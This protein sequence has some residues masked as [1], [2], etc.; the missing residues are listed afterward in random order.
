M[1]AVEAEVHALPLPAPLPLPLPLTQ[2]QH[3]I[4]LGQ[5][6]D[7]GN[8][9]YLTAE[10][11]ELTGPLD[12]DA[13][14]RAV[15]EVLDA[16]DALHMRCR[17]QGDAVW[18]QPQR[19][20]WRMARAD[21]RSEPDA[22]QA[23]HEWM[24]AA[25]QRPLDLAHDRLFDTALLRLDGQRHLWFFSAHHIALDGFGHALIA[26]ALAA[27][28]VHL[29]QHGGTPATPMDGSLARV[30]DEDQAY[31]ASAHCARDR[32]FWQQ[33]LE[34]A[35]AP[36]S[37]APPAAL[38]QTVRRGPG[39]IHADRHAAWQ[40]AARDAGV[41]VSAWLLAAVAAWLHG[42]T[43]A[44]D[45]TLGLPVM[46]RLGSATLRRPCMAMN[47]VPLRL[48]IEPHATPA[49]LA[50]QVAD[51]LRTQRP[52]QRYR[53]EHL[54]HDLGQSHGQNNARNTTPTRLFGPVV[55]WM[56]FDRPLDFGPGLQASSLPVA[57][58]PVEDLSITI[59]P[60][61]AAWQFD[62]DAN[63][64]AYRAD[65]LA[66]LRD[67][68]LTTLDRLAASPGEPLAS[69][70]PFIISGGPL[71]NAA[72]AVLAAF[73]A[74]ARATPAKTALEHEGRT[75]TYAELLHAVQSLAGH[76]K[77]RGVRADTR[78][79]VLL[80]RSPQAITALLAV[81]W[82]GGCYVP[83][84][85]DS[86]PARIAM[87]LNDAQPAW[88]LTLSEHLG[89]WH[90]DTPS[91]C[92][93]HDAPYEPPLAD[94]AEVGAQA[95]AYVIYTSGSTGQPNG[96]MIGRHALAH[97]IAGAHARY[98]ITR[99]DRMLQF[100]PLHFDASVEEI[101]LPLTAGATL[102]LR[103]DA[104]LESLPHFVAACA[105]QRIS[106]LDLPTAFWH[107]LA[108][109]L[110]HTEA[111][112]PPSVRLVVIGGEAALAER[113]ARWRASVP[114]HVRLLNTYGPTEATVVCTTAPLAGPGA[115][116]W[117]GDTVPIGQPLPGM[118]LVV[119]NAAL[120]PLPQGAAGELCLIGEAL[121][122]GYLGREERSAQR[123][124][125]L[126]ALPG[127]PRAYRTGDHVQVGP[128]GELRYLG[129]LDDELK[130][131]GHRIDP[132][133][134]ETTL[135]AAPGVRE[136]AVVGQAL[137]D[138]NKRLVAFIVADESFD[139]R[140]F[141]ANALRAFAAARLPAVAVPSAHVQLARLPRNLN[142]KID[143]NALREQAAS[144]HLDAAVDVAT[145]ASTDA[146]TSAPTHALEQAV[147][148]VWREVLG[149]QGVGATADF[150]A[151]GGKSLQAIQVANRLGVALQ[152]EVA[153]S[154]LFLHP[155]VGALAQA[156]AASASRGVGH[157]PP[158]SAAGHELAPL[159]AIQP[160]AEGRDDP[161]LFCIH[162][163]E[164]LAWCYFGLSRALPGV[165]LWGLQ[166]QG[167]TGEAPASFDAM[168]Q[169]GVR[170]IR[171]QQPHGPYHLLGWSSGGGLAHALA[172]RLQAE[173]ERVGLL[174]VM[175]AYP[176]EAFA[177]KP[178]PQARDALEAVL[179]VIGAS[180][181][182]ATGQPLSTDAMRALL[183]RP[184]SALAGFGDALLDR[185]VATAQH[186][187][188]LYREARHTRFDGDLL[189]FRAARRAPDAPDWP[190]WAPHV[191]G[192]IAVTDIDS[193]H[194]GMSQPAPLAHI[195]RVL[196]QHLLHEEPA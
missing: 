99:D 173:G 121:A 71:P 97:F 129:R 21:L 81:L 14:E 28:Y 85:P 63:P 35:A 124:V 39:R 29:T 164:G 88:V 83:I 20:P 11:I 184:G 5:Q 185:M 143:R 108:Y 126:H 55:N 15:G 171:A 47:I 43:G 141:D 73:R 127:A 32:V 122:Q 118:S 190:A 175:D 36:V 104:M 151:L 12:A 157:T 125:Q 136:A 46:N 65:E 92:L 165:P 135:L 187:M 169:D 94:P 22:D 57:A 110:G 74:H 61:G 7:P 193:T 100:A 186:T 44:H 75:V 160:A 19:E 183:L 119:V 142:N 34:G 106:V 86:P 33:Q 58:G 154:T 4:W 56:P 180:P 64:N 150:F 49:T 167:I 82:A 114:P 59:A 67:D 109:S 144:L 159:L 23:A 195:G 103:N 38:A 113:V 102:V 30:V 162:P 54:R 153:V 123:F 60:R 78:V 8:P 158:P 176:S 115:L 45:L 140:P 128:D 117:H 41:D 148:A 42:R 80:P 3:G 70:P 111:A 191:S 72:V 66:A 9:A 52:H 177:H 6:M 91:L 25:L 139:T 116:S 87:V 27:R 146:S 182:D 166:A 163:A 77:A 188:A 69:A 31:A 132:N 133:E 1:G 192:R 76:L 178:A 101:F 37:L 62:V 168:V 89:P 189:F 26:S 95:L 96:V 179:D 170:R 90:G 149:V 161:A 40:Q 138:G 120:R 155:T 147:I 174:A 105:Q 53:Y 68:L 18:Q 84:D 51:Q 194:P 156:L 50:R 130:I 112:L 17:V 79:A 137:A 152:R 16:C 13:L 93:D 145:D 134:I 2:A 181:F 196:A 107:E 131:S 24:Q 48:R 172:A 98:G 10:A